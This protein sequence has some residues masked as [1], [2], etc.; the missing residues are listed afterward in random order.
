MPYNFMELT[1]PH[2]DSKEECTTFLGYTVQ[3]TMSNAS[4]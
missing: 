1:R 3:F 4:A 2:G